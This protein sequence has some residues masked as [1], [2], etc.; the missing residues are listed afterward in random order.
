MIIDATFRFCSICMP[1][2]DKIF[3][4]IQSII[5]FTHSV[6]CYCWLNT[7]RKQL[8]SLNST[9]INNSSIQFNI[10]SDKYCQSIHFVLFLFKKLILIIFLFK[11]LI[12]IKSSFLFTNSFKHTQENR[13]E[14]SAWKMYFMKSQQILSLLNK[15]KIAQKCS[16]SNA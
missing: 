2:S 6:Y 8:R 10:F 13:V 11:N 5:S 3:I 1:K 7:L 9:F 14:I 16:E 4:V 12:S 15:F